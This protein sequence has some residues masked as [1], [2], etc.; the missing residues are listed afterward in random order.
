[1]LQTPKE[2]D[3]LDGVALDPSN[4]DSVTAKL[5]V[6]KTSAELIS[7]FDDDSDD[8]D[9]EVDLTDYTEEEIG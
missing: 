7:P 8:S 5:A 3:S 1:M 2:S 4:I 9:D 6:L